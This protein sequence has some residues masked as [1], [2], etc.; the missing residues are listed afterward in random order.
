MTGSTTNK[1][2]IGIVLIAIYTGFSALLSLGMGIP[3][4][5]LGQFAAE[6]ALISI[7]LITFG[8][9][10]LATTYGL[11]TLEDWGYKLAK[12]VYMISIPLGVVALASDTSTGNIVM[13]IIGIAVAAWILFYLFK[14]EIKSLYVSA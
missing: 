11:W 6:A 10:A 1:K 3:A 9:L 2:P 8:V 5:F 14:P 4:M 12:I 13:Q 7:F